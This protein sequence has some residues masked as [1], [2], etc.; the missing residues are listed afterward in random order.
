MCKAYNI[1]CNKCKKPGHY[2]RFCNKVSDLIANVEFLDVEVK[3]STNPET[4][5]TALAAL[6]SSGSWHCESGPG[7]WSGRFIT[8]NKPGSGG[9]IHH[10]SRPSSNE[11]RG[12]QVRESATVSGSSAPCT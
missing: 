11:S 5:I 6:E 3:R 9:I 7:P 4:P 12:H 10:E 1:L 8:H 2:G